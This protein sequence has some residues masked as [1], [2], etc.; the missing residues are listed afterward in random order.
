[1]IKTLLTKIGH[2]IRDEDSVIPHA[3]QKVFNAAKSI[4]G[5][6]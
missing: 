5:R 4:K 6:H 1:M 3:I 2:L